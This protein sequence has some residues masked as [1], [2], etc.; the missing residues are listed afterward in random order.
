MNRKRILMQKQKRRSSGIHGTI[1]IS[2]LMILL[3]LLWYGGDRRFDRADAATQ[4]KETVEIRVIGTTDLHGQLNSKDYELGVDYNNGGLARV[5][6]L[7]TRTRNERPKENTITLDAGDVLYDYTTEYIFSEDQSSIQPIYQAMAMIGYDAITLGNHDFD[8][9]YEYLLRQLNGSGLR[10]ITVVSNVTDSKTGKYPFH[11]TML[12]TRQMKTT[13]GKTV[14][15]TIGI[16][17]Q[18]IPTLT[19]K[20]HSYAGIL[21]T[22]DMVQN[23]KTKAA[24]LKEMGADIIIALSHTGIGPENPELNFKNVAYALSKIPEIDVIV[25]G[26][27]HNLFP[28]T[29][30]TSPYYKLPNVDKETYLMNGKNVI[31]AGDRGKAIGVVDL[32]LQVTEEGVEIIDR[33]SELRMVTANS[34]KEDK[35]LAGLYGSWEDQLLEYSTDVI[36]ELDSDTVIQNWYGLLGDNPAI[37]LLNDSKIQYALHFTYNTGTAY[38]DYPIIAASTYGSYGAGSIDDF[39]NIRDQITESELSV[40]QPYNNYLYVYTITGKQLKEWLEWSASAYETLS[41]GRTWTDPVMS[42]LMK[43]TGL[44]SLIKEE[45][46]NDW[47]NFFIFDGIDYVIDPT[48]EARYDFS[49]NKI[50]NNRRIKSLKLNGTDV[51]DDMVFL[52]ST[53]KITIPVEANQGVEKQAVF[54]GFNR[55]QSILGKYLEREYRNGSLMPQVDYNWSVSLP[56][57]YRF[58]VK[59]PYY[60]EKHFK[61]S[62]YYQSDLTVANQYHYYIAAYQQENKDKISP[63]IIT[64]PVVT[65]ATASPYEVALQVSDASEIKAVRMQKGNYDLKDPSWSIARLLSNPR[66][67]VYDNGIYSIYAEDIYGNKTLKKLVVDNFDENLLSRPTVDSYTN[68]KTKISGKAEPMSTIVFEAYTGIYEDKVGV[69]GGFSYALPAQP[70]GTIVNVYIKDE[71]KGLVSERVQVTVKRT[72]PNQPSLLPLSNKMNYIQGDT[73]DDDASVIVM[74]DDFVYVAENGGKELYEKAADI[75][76]SKAK[77]IESSFSVDSYGYFTMMLPPQEAGKSI[78]IYNI[79]HL[80]RISRVATIKVNEVAPNA[81]VVYE[82]SN[83]EKQVTGNVPGAGNKIYTVALKLGDKTYTTKTNKEGDFTFS[84]NEQLKAGQL[85]SVTASDMM[86]GATRESFPTTVIV[87]DIEKYL[88]LSSTNLTMNRVTSKTSIVSGYYYDGGT[89]FL[90]ISEGEG[91]SFKNTLYTLTTDEFSR[92]KLEL[93]NKLE[94]GMKVY[95]MARF[96]E[97]RILLAN[98]TDVLP[99]RPEMPILIKEVTNADKL[100]QVAADINS[101]ITLTIGSKKYITKEYK[102]DQDKGLYIYSFETDREASGVAITV[103]ASNEAGTSELLSSKIV[104]AAP[105]APVVKPIKSSDKK[106]TGTIELLDYVAPKAEIP[107]NP[108]EEEPAATAPEEEANSSDG[109]ESSPKTGKTVESIQPKKDT[110]GKQTE[111][112]KTSD[113]SEAGK[114]EEKQSDEV[115]ETLRNAPKK[116][117]A[118]QTRVFAQIG[119]KTYEGTIDAKGNF[120][121]QIPKQKAGTAIKLWGTNKAGRGPLVK[122]VVVK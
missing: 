87:N 105:D 119:K 16:I 59:T 34:T 38:K 97:G 82:V 7:I 4:K 95:V 80:S 89:V 98:R 74:V 75:Y 73:N 42:S 99:S 9:G 2:L 58:I 6:D 104:K 60:A 29:D 48:L 40:L 13:S 27:E 28:T 17:G 11:E 21:K 26:H 108:E 39:I 19:S 77:V 67:T 116:V 43:E 18:T 56:S 66:F 55:S 31:M 25:S 93:D 101:E 15:V 103:S 14:E 46:L 110:S 65:S 3:S 52:L 12:I 10:N 30:M 78:T 122:V 8:Y 88:R 53:N 24:Q 72:G 47:S 118:T 32:S 113:K 120:T 112:D 83:I 111:A 79:D 71:A 114:T 64:A 102:K 90:A 5:M 106:I 85:L 63:T 45:W 49:G 1:G 92:Y 62:P 81:P 69:N 70:S 117:A 86:N 96:M 50:S 51:K 107:V 115:P 68:R 37:Q 35:K 23:A 121:I 44:K 84:F 20:T 76:N 36:G 109:S 100:V 41:R 94:P 22:E 57:S 61:A 33:K 91:E 54:S